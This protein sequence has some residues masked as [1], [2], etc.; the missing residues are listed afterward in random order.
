[1]SDDDCAICCAVCLIGYTGCVQCASCLLQR[2]N[3][4]VPYQTHNGCLTLCCFPLAPCML[5]CPVDMWGREVEY[6]HKNVDNTKPE[7]EIT[8]KYFVAHKNHDTCHCCGVQCLTQPPYNTK[9]KLVR[10]RKHNTT[11]AAAEFDPLLAQ[12]LVVNSQSDAVVRVGT[13]AYF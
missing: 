1:M 4:C 3:G 8:T 12:P 6:K 13:R 10:T 5:C 9:L 2:G 11:A 7:N